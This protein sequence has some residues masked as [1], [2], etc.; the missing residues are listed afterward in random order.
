L[1]LTEHLPRA[2]HTRLG[3]QDLD[4]ESPSH[5]DHPAPRLYGREI[6]VL[7][8]AGTRGV[9][10]LA[11][12]FALPLTTDSGDPFPD[13]ELLLFCAFLTVLV[14]LV[15]QGLTFGPL[16]RALGIRADQADQAKQRNEARTAAVQAAL[17]RLDEF[18]AERHDAVEDQAIVAL[19]AQLNSRLNR[20]RSRLQDLENAEAGEIPLSPQ[21]EANLRVRRAVIG[22]Q[23][24]ELLRWRDLGRLPDESLRILERE[25]DHEEGLLPVRSVS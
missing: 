1:C 12:I 17:G 14:T 4:E 6:V 11:A 25:L 10:T 19:R 15:L 20:Y 2:L 3:G 23:R 22:A 7:S 13:R 24:E 18:A 5:P 8:W 21:Y 9:I 16:V